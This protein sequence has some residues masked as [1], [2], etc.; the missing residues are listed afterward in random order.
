MCVCETESEAVN[1]CGFMCRYVH[2]NERGQSKEK[3]LYGVSIVSKHKHLPEPYPV[4]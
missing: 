2:M 3:V 4:S 1:L